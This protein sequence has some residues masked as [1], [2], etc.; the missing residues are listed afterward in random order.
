M[1]SPGQG[2]LDAP[3]T[4]I[5]RFERNMTVTS[6]DLSEYIAYP[7]EATMVGV[8]VFCFIPSILVSRI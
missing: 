7:G 1:G 6:S 4:R 3:C 5:S 2:L 8:L